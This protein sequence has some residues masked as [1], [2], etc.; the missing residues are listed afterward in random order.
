MPPGSRPRLGGFVR[1]GVRPLPD[2]RISARVPA[3]SRARTTTP[4]SFRH[5]FVSG[6]RPTPGPAV[7]VRVCDIGSQPVLWPFALLTAAT[8][9]AA[10]A[11]STRRYHRRQSRGG[12]APRERHIHKAARSWCPAPRRRAAA[13][14][15][16]SRRPTGRCAARGMVGCVPLVTPRGD[17][18]IPVQRSMP[19]FAQY[20]CNKSGS[21]SENSSPAR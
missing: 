3:L 10:P 15:A 14:I 16:H 8:T 20:A 6:G 18:V 2:L 12:R 9:G 4:P 13:R 21:A 1:S 19:Y 7:L 5:K 11:R 17:R